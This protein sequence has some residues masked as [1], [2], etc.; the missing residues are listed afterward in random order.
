MST[1]QDRFHHSQRLHRD[2]AAVARQVKIA[3]E[4]GIDVGEPHRLDHRLPIERKA[5]A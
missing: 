2:D 4:H 1:E 5:E 3:Q